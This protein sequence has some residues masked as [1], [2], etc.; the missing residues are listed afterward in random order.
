MLNG[1]LLY[2]SGNLSSTGEGSV[3]A[4]ALPFAAS[5]STT[6]E[7]PVGAYSLRLLPTGGVVPYMTRPGPS[8]TG[9]G[10]PV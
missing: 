10:R 8:G 5:L 2:A 1:E 4:L 6:T 9:P 3:T 7:E